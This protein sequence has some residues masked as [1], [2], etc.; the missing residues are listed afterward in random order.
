[1]NLTV[2]DMSKV[3]V[4][5]SRQYMTWSSCRYPHTSPS[6][7]VADVSCCIH[8]TNYEYCSHTKQYTKYIS[9]RWIYLLIFWV[10]LKSFDM[11]S[12]FFRHNLGNVEHCIKNAS[13]MLFI[14]QW[15]AQHEA[16]DRVNQSL[17]KF[18]SASP[19]VYH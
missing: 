9:N 10:L 16:C 3:V 5:L 17:K 18:G 8:N 6:E 7:Q 14:N 12:I 13:L 2:V 19:T 4:S 15:H 1:M 11:T